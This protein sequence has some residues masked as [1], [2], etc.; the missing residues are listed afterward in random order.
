M[1][2]LAALSSPFDI[3]GSH[4]A[5]V[6]HEYRRIALQ[7]KLF[8]HIQAALKSQDYPRLKA[9]SQRLMKTVSDQRNASPMLLRAFSEIVAIIPGWA[10][11]MSHI[12]DTLSLYMQMV[13]SLTVPPDGIVYITITNGFPDWDRWEQ[14]I[15]KVHSLLVAINKGLLEIIRSTERYRHEL[16]RTMDIAVAI[17]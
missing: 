13:S 6:A 12:K 4:V 8:A 16:R 17:N 9:Y 3:L 7:G 11:S 14:E 1:Q 15:S 2:D 5:Q 10:A